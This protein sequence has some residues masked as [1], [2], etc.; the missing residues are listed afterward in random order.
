MWR[1]S[2]DPVDGLKTVRL[3]AS[4]GDGSVSWRR[5]LRGVRDVQR[6]DCG[7]RYHPLELRCRRDSEL[8]CRIRGVCARARSAS[9]GLGCPARA[10]GKEVRARILHG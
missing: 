10:N 6:K 2:A 5:N 7:K 4:D 8:V 1:P 9:G 3:S